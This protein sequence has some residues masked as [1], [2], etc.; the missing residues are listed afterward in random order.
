ECLARATV[1]P[2][3]WSHAILNSMPYTFL[4]DAP[5]EERRARAV[6]TARPG[7]LLPEDLTRLDP[8]AIGAVLDELAVEL[9]DADELHDLL[10][11][12]ACVAPRDEWRGFFDEL[13]AAGRAAVHRD[14]WVA[15]EKLLL[16]QSDAGPR[17]MVFGFLQSSAPIAAAAISSMLELPRSSIE[18]A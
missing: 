8:D 17:L 14:R 9:R 16:L 5:L 11:T 15:V 1:A 7:E 12:A 18:H 10:C 4:D 2:S 6:M 13:A 3:P